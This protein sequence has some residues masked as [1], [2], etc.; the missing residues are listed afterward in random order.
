[1]PSCRP[2]LWWQCKIL[3]W[4]SWDPLLL[5]H[6]PSTGTLAVVLM[7]EKI[8]QS[9]FELK[10]PVWNFKANFHCT[11]NGYHYISTTIIMNKLLFKHTLTLSFISSNHSW[12]F[13]QYGLFET[14]HQDIYTTIC[15][16]QK[17]GNDQVN[18]QFFIKKPFCKLVLCRF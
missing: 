16:L 11:W 12:T 10:I 14:S 1:M 15:E 17:Q 4:R 7:E 9:T 8:L 2:T 6:D 5:A 3:N 18:I 13:N